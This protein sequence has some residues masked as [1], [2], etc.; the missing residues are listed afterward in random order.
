MSNENDSLKSKLKGVGYNPLAWVAILIAL[1]AM[2]VIKPA[3]WLTKEV[4]DKSGALPW[5]AGVAASAAAGI[6]LGYHLGWV[7][8][9]SP[10]YWIAG[11]VGAVIGTYFYA[12]PL[13][14]LGV[15]QWSFKASGKLWKRVPDAGRSANEY[16]FSP[17]F[18]NTLTF[19]TQAA[20]VIGGFVLFWNMADGIHDKIGW[21]DGFLNLVNWVISV[22][23]S[24][25]LS[26]IVSALAITFLSQSGL[27]LIAAAMGAGVTYHYTPALAGIVEAH[28]WPYYAKHVMQAGVFVGFVAYVFPLAHLFITRVFRGIGEWIERAARYFFDH[29]GKFI[30]SAYDEKDR[31]YEGFLQQVVGIAATVVAGSYAWAYVGTFGL[32][33]IPAV[34]VTVIAVLAAYIILCG[35]TKQIG[36]EI[37]GAV[38]V[39]GATYHLAVHDFYY[40]TDLGILATIGLGAAALVAIALIGYPIAYNIV[41]LIARPLLSSWLAQPLVNLHKSL[42]EEIFRSFSRTYSDETPFKNFFAHTVNLASTYGVFVGVTALMAGLSFSPLVAISVTVL[43]SI[44]A[45]LGVG[46]LFNRFDNPLIGT[47]ASI[48]A[49]VWGGTMAYAH[50]DHSLWYGVGGFLVAG[51]VNFLVVYPVTYV[52]LKAVLN[53]VRVNDWALPFL[54]GVHGFFWSFVE[55]FWNLIVEAWRFIEENARPYWQKASAIIDQSWTSAMEVVKHIFGQKTDKK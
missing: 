30:S 24:G 47:L 4:Y 34:A 54:S 9:L 23:V 44:A 35:I 41:R 2:S 55:S 29:F 25:V 5:I 33:L 27:L 22:V 51:V 17:W 37:I 20:I 43:A 12:Y 46:K 45:Y 52:V 49:G 53:V 21:T 6:G 32:S 16:G 31:N 28:E 48:G 13:A 14:H 7:L 38:I 39:L 1:V 50:F 3:K 8:N 26:F 18:S 19:L 36:L 40:F 15:F 42:S 11:G 10:L